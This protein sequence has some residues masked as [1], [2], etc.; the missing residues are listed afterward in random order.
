LPRRAT[1]RSGSQRGA[2]SAAAAAS[3]PIIRTAPC[4]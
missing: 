4:G 2:V 3:K 1:T